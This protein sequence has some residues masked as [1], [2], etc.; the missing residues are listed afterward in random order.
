VEPKASIREVPGV[1][2]KNASC[3]LDHIFDLIMF[4]ILLITMAQL[5]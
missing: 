3:V 5:G 1:C 4:M 2:T